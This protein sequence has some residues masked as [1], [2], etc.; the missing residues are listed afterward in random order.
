MVGRHREWRGLVKDYEMH[1]EGCGT[2]VWGRKGDVLDDR[3]VH[4][5]CDWDN[6]QTQDCPACGKR[7]GRSS[8]APAGFP[9]CPCDGHKIPKL[10]WPWTSKRFVDAYCGYHMWAFNQRT[11]GGWKNILRIFPYLLFGN[12]T[13]AMYRHARIYNPEFFERKRQPATPIANQEN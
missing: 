8:V 13:G 4:G 7:V 3:T 10:R 12:Y 9:D 5:W 11:D 1:C 2:F 6:C